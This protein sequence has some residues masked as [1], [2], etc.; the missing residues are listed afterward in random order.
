M[1]YAAGRAA[2]R[3]DDQVTSSE[4]LGR[5]RHEVNVAILRRRAAMTRAVQPRPT[6]RARWLLT[7]HTDEEAGSGGRAP[8]LDVDDTSD[9]GDELDS[10]DFDDGGGSLHEGAT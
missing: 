7:G 8:Q 9:S 3:G 2:G 6:A 4:F 5:W 1:R 10:E